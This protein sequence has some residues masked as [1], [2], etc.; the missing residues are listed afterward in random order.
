M[1]EVTDTYGDPE[2]TYQCVKK[3]ISK[4]PNL[5]G[6]YI[7]EG[8]TPPFAAKAVEESNKNIKI[9]GHDIEK[10]IA[11][12]LKSKKIHASFSQNLFAQGYNPVIDLFNYI[13]CG[14][15]PEKPRQVVNIDIITPDNFTE[16]WEIGGGLVVSSEI[17]DNLSKPMEISQ[18]R[19]R[20]L[21]SGDERYPIYMQIKQGVL[22]AKRELESYNAVVD[23]IAP[24]QYLIPNGP[25]LDN[26]KM[27]EFLKENMAKNYNALA[28]MVNYTELVPYLN[29]LVEK[30]VPVSSFNS[31]P[32]G[33][34]GLV[35]GVNQNVQ[36]LL[37][38]SEILNNSS[39]E[40]NSAMQEITSAIIEI[41]EGASNQSDN[42]QEGL[43]AVKKLDISIQNVIDGIEAQTNAIRNSS[44]T[45]TSLSNS[46]IKMTHQ[47]SNIDEMQNKV[48]LSVK[49]IQ[50][51]KEY[52]SK[53]VDIIDTIDDISNQTNLLAL[54][55]SIEVHMQEFMERVLM[56]SQAK[57]ESLH[58]QQIVPRP[59]YQN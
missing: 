58:Y 34:R 27:I 13:S 2:N 42:A 51:I 30:G 45:G 48:D 3:W 46:I 41:S 18:K 57:S 11:E 47:I 36:E 38:I 19:I 9:L 43:E 20:I 54:N 5:K 16:F 55:A 23:W 12:Y 17:R 14:W 25:I 28:L 49:K 24:K 40:T 29:D 59:M 31:E 21:V 10:E 22:E 1:V 52:S 7:V 6:I 4:F 37:N 56:S 26:D 35:S 32:L 39:N 50:Q 8:L 53:M 33:L 15:K 44:S